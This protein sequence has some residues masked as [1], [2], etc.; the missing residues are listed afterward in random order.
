MQK[1]SSQV[2][3]GKLE[4]INALHSETGLR[5]ISEYEKLEI[6]SLR[7]AFAHPAARREIESALGGITERLS[8]CHLQKRDA[9][10]AEDVGDL[11]SRLAWEVHKVLGIMAILI[12]EQEADIT[13][14]NALI[15]MISAIDRD[16]FL[17]AGREIEDV[18][19]GRASV[20]TLQAALDRY[21]EKTV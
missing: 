14:M 6:K 9:L 2:E 8:L 1:Y 5:L 20:A 7:T 15:D 10:A 16:F 21:L 17:F 11:E 18:L 13:E 19:A 3:Q 12:N 4:A